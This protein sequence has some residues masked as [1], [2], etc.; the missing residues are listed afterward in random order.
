MSF[1]HS[2]HE[3]I[4]TAAVKFGQLYYYCINEKLANDVWLVSKMLIGYEEALEPTKIGDKS[5][6]SNFDK[7]LSDFGS[8][9]VI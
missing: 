3:N 8:F 1:L 6:Q 4:F 7:P 2:K 9:L 5:C